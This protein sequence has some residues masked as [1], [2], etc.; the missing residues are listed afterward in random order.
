M[1]V[2]LLT[3]GITEFLASVRW[4]GSF[5]YFIIALTYCQGFVFLGGELMEDCWWSVNI[6]INETYKTDLFSKEIYYEKN[7]S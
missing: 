1:S 4:G 7:Y 3:G 2:R 5:F 6:K